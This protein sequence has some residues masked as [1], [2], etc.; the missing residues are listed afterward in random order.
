MIRTPARSLRATCRASALLLLSCTAAPSFAGSPQV[1]WNAGGHIGVNSVALSPDGAM[2]ATCSAVDNTGKLW[3]VSDGTLVHTLAAHYAGVQSTAISPDGQF[4]ATTG[5]VAHGSG[6]VP[7]KLWRVDDGTLVR[8][9]TGDNEQVSTAVSFSPNGQLLAC[10]Q[11]YVLRVWRVSTGQLLR[12]FTGH[13][14]TVFDSAFSPDGVT[15][16]SASGDGTIKIWNVQTGAL[17]RTLTGHTF[18]VMSLAYSTDGS[19]LVSGSFDNTVKLWNVSTGTVI[20]SLTGQ[21]DGVYGVDYAPDGLTVASAAGDNTVV[22]WRVSDG[23]LL[24]TLPTPYASSVE[25][26]ADGQTLVAGAFDSHVYRWQLSDGALLRTFGAHA[27]RIPDVAYSRAGDLLASASHD[28]TARLW[29]P[30]TG[31]LQV[32]LIGHADA[33]NGVS[34]SPDGAQIATAAGSGP[35]TPDRTIKIW[36]TADGALVRTLAGHTD[37]TSDVSWSPLGTYLVSGG[38]D[39]ALKVWDPPTGN[40]LL[41][42]PIGTV[43]SRVAFSPDGSTLA[44]CSENGTVKLYEPGAWSLIR[45]IAIVDNAGVFAM[46][47]SPDGQTIAVALD[48]YGNNIQTYRVADGTRVRTYSGF[49][50][51]YAQGVAFAPDGATLAGSSG[52][53]YEITLWSV[54]DGT[55]LVTYNQDTGWG[56]WVALPLAFAPLGSPG[57][58]TFAYG[59]ADATVDVAV[60][61]FAVT[62]VREPVAG[63]GA[64]ASL[65]VARSPAR[66]RVEFTLAPSVLGDAR[67]TIYDLR[68]RV[69]RM[70]ASAGEHGALVWNGRDAAGRVAPSGAY[71][72]RTPS[73]AGTR[74][75]WLR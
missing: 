42:L 10:G 26:A 2:L 62:A 20:R 61:P 59:R 30:L 4:V 17:V 6:E 43:P 66:G 5:D 58:G 31:A 57:A 28:F 41:T 32:S 44:A 71:L 50:V 75:V 3:R 25:Y 60:N 68:G 73:N 56:P 69:V 21:G 64:T 36:T 52:Y 7:V 53:T 11:G 47:W 48:Q 39:A 54:A 12:S 38:R 74:F 63:R 46:D 29:N 27:A 67:V 16:A 40:L 37:G 18:F 22:Q 8:T 34:F 65:R 35:G 9:F 15:V 1:V 33:L 23:A 70:L 13:T 49:T 55:P 72:A 24:R 51:G 14:W 45:S 19:T